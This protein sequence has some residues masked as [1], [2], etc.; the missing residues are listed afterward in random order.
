MVGQR[1]QGK[2]N[3][4]V[5]L[6][7][8]NN[9]EPRRQFCG[10][11]KPKET[12]KSKETDHGKKVMGLLESLEKTAKRE[13]KPRRDQRI[14]ERETKKFLSRYTVGTEKNENKILFK[15]IFKGGLLGPSNSR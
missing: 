14:L 6:G 10:S 13:R 1:I 9:A 15:D 3:R 5:R 4:V 12:E 11:S 7:P 2:N 8:M